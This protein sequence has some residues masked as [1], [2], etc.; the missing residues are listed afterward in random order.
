[1][2]QANQTSASVSEATQAL[3][4]PVTPQPSPTQAPTSIPPTATPTP[5]PCTIAFD[6]E[7]GGKRQ[8]FKM[9]SQGENLTP[10]TNKEIESKEPAFSPDG[11]SIAYISSDA[12]TPG[13]FLFMM[14]SD[15]NNPRQISSIE[16]CKKP[17]WS[18]DGRWIAFEGHGD[19]Y[20]IETQGKEEAK[21][22]TES[23]EIDWSVSIS[24]DSTTLLWLSKTNNVSS[25]QLMK[26]NGTEK[27]SIDFTQEIHGASWTYDGNISISASDPQKLGCQNCMLNPDNEQFYDAGGKDET[28]KLNPFFTDEGEQV[29]CGSLGF[30]GRKLDKNKIFLIGDIYPEFFKMISQ[31]DFDDQ[32]PTWPSGCIQGRELKKWNPPQPNTE[33]ENENQAMPDSPQKAGSIGYATDN[34]DASAFKD[35][36]YNACENLKT[37]CVDGS[38]KELVEAGIPAIVVRY[39]KEDPENQKKLLKK[40]VEKGLTV[41]LV[42]KTTDL[43]G[44]YSI[45]YNRERWA[46]L[47]LGYLL[48]R[49]KKQGEFAVFD[50]DPKYSYTKQIKE[51][52]EKQPQVKVIDL[53]QG[54]PDPRKVKPE[55][56]DLLREHPNLKAIWSS[57]QNTEILNELQQDFGTQAE[58]WPAILCDATL[59]GLDS[60]LRAKEKLPQFSCYA[61]GMPPT[62]NYEAA[63]AAY[64][65]SKGEKLKPGTLAEDNKTFYAHLLEIDDAFAEVL[66]KDMNG[67]IAPD[68]QVMSFL[69]V[70]EIRDGWFLP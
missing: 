36:F 9:N 25:L 30:I 62:I 37:Q 53:A 22:L 19:I 15:G 47:Q 55:T 35:S 67:R 58:K 64:Y 13:H 50:L 1:M 20:L 45:N 26:I 17:K 52:L 59:V 65:L 32:N 31:G 46:K 70:E 63:V 42:E 61:V 33:K 69:S 40:A 16:D 57:A 43:A 38:L 60:W 27:K 3:P 14:N 12:A 18:A 23:Q 34:F 39:E 41:I 48:E 4:R 11:K 66:Y 28:Y 44:I 68:D 24:P 8:I 49:T 7:R 29:S 6:S 56:G 10:L 2:P 51:L 5:I 54:F 21:N